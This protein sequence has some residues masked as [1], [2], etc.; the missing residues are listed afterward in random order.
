MDNDCDELTD[1]DSA[2]DST[3]FYRDVDG[4]GFGNPFISDR[5]CFAGNG[6]VDNDTDCNDSDPL[7]HPNG[8]E[9][10]DEVDNDCD[11]LVDDQDADVQDALSWYADIDGDGYGSGTATLACEPPFFF[12]VADATDCNDQEAAISPAAIEWCGDGIDNDYDLLVDVDDD[13]VAVVVHG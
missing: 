1:E 7:I 9:I 11:L 8:A 4:D 6:Y 13:A 12:M 3:V 5:R 10:C 2:L